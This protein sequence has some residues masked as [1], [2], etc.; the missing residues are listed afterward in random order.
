MTQFDQIA[1]NFGVSVA[2]LAVICVFLWRA[3]VWLKPRVDKLVD[4]HINLVNTTAESVA[5][6][7]ES[8]ERDSDSL[9]SISNTMAKLTN[10]QEQSM[11]TLE[12]LRAL[13]CKYKPTPLPVR[14]S[15]H[16]KDTQ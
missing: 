6:L 8:R 13:E 1:Q 5:S 4:S 3:L 14:G 2:M 9:A 11:K 10:A 15:P 7:T 16:S 12:L